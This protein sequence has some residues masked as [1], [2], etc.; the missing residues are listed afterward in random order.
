MGSQRLNHVCAAAAAAADWTQ[1]HEIFNDYTVIR[2]GAFLS[3]PLDHFHV[4]EAGR[5]AAQPKNKIMVT[6]VFCIMAL[7]C[8]GLMA[9]KVALLFQMFDF[10]DNGELTMP[11]MV[12]LMQSVT[13]AAFKV[14]LVA[15]RASTKEIE[16]LA[17]EMFT[18]ADINADARVS[19]E[20]FHDWARSNIKS[21][22]L[23][24]RFT[25]IQSQAIEQAH[26]LREQLKADR[27]AMHSTVADRYNNG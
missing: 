8:S 24:Q 16:L 15:D 10:S 4:F 19:A 2:D 6:E 21:Q 3:L 13:G 12:I 11:D 9:D 5:S 17:H 1:F 25:I 18:H 20:E 22:G 23:L 26:K 7:F 14:G 27:Q